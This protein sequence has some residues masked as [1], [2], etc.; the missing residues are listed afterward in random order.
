MGPSRPNPSG[1]MGVAGDL[2]VSRRR[3]CMHRLLLASRPHLAS[4]IRKRYRVCAREYY[5]TLGRPPRR[6]HEYASGGLG[7]KPCQNGSSPAS[8]RKLMNNP[9]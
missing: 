4:P 6:T 2:F 9:G 5:V 8:L 7:R 3:R 1:G